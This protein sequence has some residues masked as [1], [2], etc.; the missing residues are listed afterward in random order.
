MYLAIVFLP[1][2]GCLVAGLFGRLMRPRVS[3]VITS[4]LL[5]ISALL[6]IMQFFAV[7]AGHVEPEVVQI[8]PWIV[9]GDFS[10]SWALRIDTLTSVMFVVVTLVSSLVH[11]YSIGY[12]SHDPHRPRFFA[13][14][15]LFTFAMLMLVSSNNFLQLFF[16][17]EGVGLTSYLLIGFWYKRP[18]ANAAAPHLIR[19]LADTD[20]TVRYHVVRALH[21][22]GKKAKPA[23][24]ALIKVIGNNRESEPTRQWAIKTLIVTLPETRRVVVKA[25]IAASKDKKNY[26]VSQL[27]RQQVRRIDLKAAEAAGVK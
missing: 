4:G 15:S 8:M 27:A 17:W 19:M 3:E 16:G 14:L 9:S 21:T 22:F 25:L 24:P 6:S 1:L 20:R 18:A 2:L 10:V 13:Y 23:I 5:V 11:I 26:G 7:L 12:M